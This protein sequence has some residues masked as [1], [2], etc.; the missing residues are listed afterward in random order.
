MDRAPSV[1]SLDFV[2]SV[3]SRAAHKVVSLPSKVHNIEHFA[4]ALVSVSGGKASTTLCDRVPRNAYECDSAHD[5]NLSELLHPRS[6]RFESFRLTQATMLFLPYVALSVLAGILYGIFLIRKRRAEMIGLPSP[7]MKH[8]VLGNIDVMARTVP[9]YPNDAHPQGIFLYLQQKYNLPAVWYLD[10]WP[11]ADSFIFTNDP[12]IASRYATTGQSLPKSASFKRYIDALLGVNNIVSTEGAHWKSLRSMFNP[13][14]SSAHLMNLVP[15]IVEASLTFV[16]ILREKAATNEL[17][18]LEDQA[19]R[20]TIDIIG[21]VVLD[22]D[23]NSQRRDHPLVTTFRERTGLMFNTSRTFQV[24]NNLEFVRRYKLRQNGFNLDKL[25]GQEI[26]RAISKR[27]SAA[28]GPSK[29]FKDR[30]R[31]VIDLALDAYSAE[32]M[33]DVSGSVRPSAVMDATFREAAICNTKAFLFAGHVSFPVQSRASTQ[34]TLTSQDTTSSTI[35]YTLYLLHHHPRVHARL[36]AELHTVFGPSISPASIATSLRESAHLINNLTYTNAV[37]KEVLRLFPPASTLRQTWDPKQTIP[38]PTPTDTRYRAHFPLK[39]LTFWPNTLLIHRNTDYF[40][41]PASFVPERFIP[42]ETP[43]PDAKLFT[44]EG[45]EAFRA[46]EKGN[47]SCIGEQLAMIETK[48][49]LALVVPSFDFVAELEGKVA[50]CRVAGRKGEM[51]VVEETEAWEESDRKGV[52][53]MEGYGIYQMLKVSLC[54]PN[55][56]LLGPPSIR[57]RWV[58]DTRLKKNGAVRLFLNVM[59]PFDLRPSPT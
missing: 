1:T 39:G 27:G 33:V 5:L 55:C 8:W 59:H 56:P 45:K 16:D 58:A 46:F 30:K 23:L 52:R 10:L 17:F 54:T 2:F 7:P 37:I 4:I 11:V 21:K 44:E 24:L 53:T 25:I 22:A 29:S 40:P 42:Q 50:P 51:T 18:L 9:L 49:I 31:S 38:N 35:A 48:I 28:N 57:F 41:D 34:L 32:K 14:F 47:R 36:L 43:Y 26:D 15:Y 3:C 6:F 20:L 13:G 12:L 19:T